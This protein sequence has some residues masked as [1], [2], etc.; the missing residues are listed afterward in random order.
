MHAQPTVTFVE[1]LAPA[2]VLSKQSRMRSAAPQTKLRVNEE[3]A[4]ET[5]RCLSAVLHAT[6]RPSQVKMQMRCMSAAESVKGSALI[7]VR[8]LIVSSDCER[9]RYQHWTLEHMSRC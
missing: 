4:G 1:S 6:N 9:S 7:T 2:R 5:V 8:E 3:A